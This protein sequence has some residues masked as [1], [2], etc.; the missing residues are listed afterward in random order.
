MNIQ[1]SQIDFFISTGRVHLLVDGNSKIVYFRESNKFINN[2]F[3]YDL[4]NG[5]G[6]EIENKIFQRRVLI[7]HPSK[8]TSKKIV[9]WIFEID[10]LNHVKIEIIKLTIEFDKIQIFYNNVNDNRFLLELN[11][12]CSKLAD[13]ELFVYLDSSSRIDNIPR[14]DD[15]NFI[16]ET[17]CESAVAFAKKSVSRRIF[18]LLTDS[19][20]AFLELTHTD[21]KHPFV[22]KT[23]L[24]AVSAVGSINHLQ[25]KSIGLF[26]ESK[27]NVVSEISSYNKTLQSNSRPICDNCWAKNICWTTKSYLQFDLLPDTVSK[28]T[29]NCDFIRTQIEYVLIEKSRLQNQNLEF[30]VDGHTLKLV[31][32]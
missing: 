17:D 8:P 7:K 26:L 3:L 16:L 22:F 25:K 27:F 20:N 18:F 30:N 32:P 13:C 4:L 23:Q 6:P 21:F 15:Y 29:K 19:N 12:F 14:Q 28:E 31:N 1:R 11:D 24:D 9:F 10:D 5:D 2:D